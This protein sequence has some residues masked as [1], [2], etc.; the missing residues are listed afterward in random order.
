VASAPCSY[1]AWGG[2]AF[3]GHRQATTRSSS[4]SFLS[5][6]SVARQRFVGAPPPP[7]GV[8]GA[9]ASFAR[10]GKPALAVAG[11]FLGGTHAS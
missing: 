11:K 1:T 6:L 2:Y 3:S 9:A 4:V 7:A 10:A 5:V 8:S